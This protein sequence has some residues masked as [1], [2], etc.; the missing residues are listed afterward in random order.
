MQLGGGGEGGELLPLHVVELCL[1]GLVEGHTVDLQY[2]IQR[3]SQIKSFD[4]QKKIVKLSR[5][6][7]TESEVNRVPIC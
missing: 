7:F 5:I 4:K 3:L 6:R 1:V 2:N